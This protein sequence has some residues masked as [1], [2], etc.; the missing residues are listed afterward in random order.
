M[1]RWFLLALLMLACPSKKERVGE[2]IDASVPPPNGWL[3]TSEKLDAYLRYQKATLV[4]LGLEKPDAWDGGALRKF[5]DKPEAHADF[6]EWARTTNGLSEDDVTKLD[7]MMGPLTSATLLQLT[8]NTHISEEDFAKMVEKVPENQRGELKAQ[9]GFA[10]GL[11]RA[12]KELA[13][14]KDRYGEENTKLLMSRQVDLVHN[15]L[16]LMQLKAEVPKMDGSH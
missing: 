2:P 8:P 12:K 3:L 1:R 9:A 11:D 10:M 4:H 5:E 6:D 15:W 13:H 14:L 7:E 16:K